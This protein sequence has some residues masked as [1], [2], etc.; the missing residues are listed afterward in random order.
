MFSNVGVYRGSF[1]PPTFGHLET[2]TC[3]LKYGVDKVVIVFTDSNPCKPNRS[4]DEVRFEQLKILFS[5]CPWASISKKS[6]KATLQGLFED[7]TVKRIRLIVGF[8]LLSVKFRPVA[9]PEI[10]DCLAVPRNDFDLENLPKSWNGLPLEIVDIEGLLYRHASSSQLRQDMSEN[11]LRE[12]LRLVPPN[13]FEKILNKGP[14]SIPLVQVANRLLA[15]CS[16]ELCERGFSD[17][18][19]IY[20]K[21]QYGKRQLVAKI[22]SNLTRFK[23]EISGYRKLRELNLKRINI[24]TIHVAEANM[25]IMDYVKGSTLAEMMDSNLEAVRL[26]A[27]ANLEL[28]QVTA[29]ELKSYPNDLEVVAGRVAALSKRYAHAL[30]TRC[31]SLVQD[32]LKDPGMQSAVHGDPNHFNWIV[33]LDARTVFYIDFSNFDERGHAMKELYEADLC[34]WTAAKRV[35]GIGKETI[36]SIRNEYINAYLKEAPS[37]IATVAAQAYFKSYWQLR[38]IEHLLLAQKPCETE[39][40]KFLGI[41]KER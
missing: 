24:P 9:K 2:A 35:G 21:D 16:F 12:V 10:V 17:D 1:D 31:Q 30:Q 6:F 38:I 25:I 28:H 36:K 29:R 18:V 14:Y 8:D 13:L 23:S 4:S 34:F 22:F 19:V 27:K 32:F 20:I 40:V 7:P 39:L 41:Y 15:N 3:S 37:S 26:C 5:R 11:R 33:D